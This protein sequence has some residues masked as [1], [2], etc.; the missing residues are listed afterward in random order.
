M[1][2]TQIIA[3]GALDQY[4]ND[5]ATTSWWKVRYNRHTNF[6]CESVVQPF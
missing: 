6:S 2:L 4:L 1:A 3:R 5:G